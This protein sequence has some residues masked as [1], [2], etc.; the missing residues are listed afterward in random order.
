MTRVLV[1]ERGHAPSSSHLLFLGFA[2]ATSW[3]GLHPPPAVQPPKIE[4]S[5]QQPKKSDGRKCAGRQGQHMTQVLVGD[6]REHAPEFEHQSFPAASWAGMLTARRA[7]D[8]FNDTRLRVTERGPVPAQLRATRAAVCRR[9]TTPA[10]GTGPE[11]RTRRSAQAG[12]RPRPFVR[13]L[14]LRWPRTPGSRYQPPKI[15]TSK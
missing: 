11:R 13:K 9:P 15:E 1:V 7:A 8:A 4:T 5:K 3:A 12:C 10:G 6:A 2:K 14:R